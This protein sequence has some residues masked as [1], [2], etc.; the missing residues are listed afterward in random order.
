MN[1]E[2]ARRKQAALDALSMKLKSPRIREPMAQIH[3]D[4]GGE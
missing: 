2:V 1:E 4:L 3:S